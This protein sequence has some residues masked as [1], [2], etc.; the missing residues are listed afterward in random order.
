MQSYNPDDM[1]SVVWIFPQELKNEEIFKNN[2]E[3]T[4]N[5]LKELIKEKAYLK[6]SDEILSVL[7]FDSQIEHQ[8]EIGRKH[9]QNITKIK[10]RMND[11]IS[12]YKWV[13]FE[14][15]DEYINKV[16]VKADYAL[17]LKNCR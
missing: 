4:Y 2:I 10:D 14:H 17:V 9:K 1:I 6:A 8:K 13:I 16:S 3:H 5:D 12:P 11:G 7:K 15:F